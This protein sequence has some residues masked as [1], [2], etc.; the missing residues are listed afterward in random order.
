MP[1]I[2]SSFSYTFSYCR[3]ILSLPLLIVHRI[4]ESGGKI[5]WT[6]EEHGILLAILE[7]YTGVERHEEIP[8]TLREVIDLIEKYYADG[9]LLEKLYPHLTDNIFAG[10]LELSSNKQDGKDNQNATYG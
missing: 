5:A 1:S 8:I 10:L 7:D 9:T 6:V 3:P 4:R 2:L